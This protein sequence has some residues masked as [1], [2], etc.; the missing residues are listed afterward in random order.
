MAKSEMNERLFALDYGVVMRIE[1]DSLTVD[2]AVPDPRWLEQLE[3]AGFSPCRDPKPLPTSNEGAKLRLVPFGLMP[4]VRWSSPDFVKV[5]ADLK[6]HEQLNKGPTPAGGMELPW[7]N[8]GTTGPSLGQIL[9]RLGHFAEG[10][11]KVIN[12]VRY[13]WKY[14]KWLLLDP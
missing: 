1:G 5:A 13:V 12:G 6:Q 14:G 3:E 2:G 10:S 11:I 8:P 7:A 9:R 4:S